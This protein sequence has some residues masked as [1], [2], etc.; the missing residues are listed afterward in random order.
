MLS[1][2]WTTI[3]E[4]IIVGIPGLH[5]DYYGLVS[6]IFFV[7]YITTVAGNMFFLVLFVTTESLRKPMYII[8][9]SLALSDMCFSTVAL[10]K[11]ISKYWFNAGATP[12]HACFFQMELI[13]YFGSLNSL[14][15]MI[16]AL[17]RYVAICYS[18]RYQT[19]MTNRVTYILIT[20]AWITAFIAP[21]VATLDTQQLPYCGPNLILQCYCDHISIT[22][23]ACAENSK[24][25]L[26]AL[27]MALLV[28][29]LPLVCIIYSYCHIIASVMRLS[30]S[31]S[32]W[33]SF[34]TCSTQLCIITL[35]YMPRFTVYLT[36]FLQIQISKD[37]RILLVLIYCL[38]PPLV[39]P[40][41][42]CLRTQEI[43]M[44]VSR[45]VS[46]QQ[47]LRVACKINVITL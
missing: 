22:N 14:I 37:F 41:I 27:C 17:D 38:V 18:L 5:P 44:I 4:F 7:I 30:S 24:Q 10:P 19:V 11:I 16:M 36:T 34:A 6:A 9:A 21:T 20:T 29:L 26:V 46:R 45:W 40:F 25:L 15:M 33:K 39:N 47:A 31:Q 23:L 2:N 3:S 28:L 13:H 8:L 43:R 1:K 32:R 12:F 42:Y 35:F